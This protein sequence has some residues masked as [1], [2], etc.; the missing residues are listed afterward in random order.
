[1]MEKR[2]LILNAMQELLMKGSS[3]S[4][5]DVAKKAGIAKGGIYYYYPSKEEILNALVDKIYYQII[6]NCRQKL[7]QNNVNAIEK[8]NILVTTY[9]SSSLNSSVDTYLHLPQNAQIHQKSLAKI[10]TSLSPIFTNIIIQ[11]N[12]EGTFDCPYPEE[13]S[14]MFLS[15]FTFLFD[16]GIFEWEAEK[17]Q[18][19]L[20]AFADLI[21]R[22]LRIP[23]GSMCFLYNGELSSHKV[24]PNI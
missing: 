10:L 8:I 14:E 24:K 2:E 9:F 18:S 21:E 20:V 23:S 22:S 15:I 6:E 16:P 3:F 11:G 7:A 13:F 12:E 19:K 4:I 5:S 1:M 17:I